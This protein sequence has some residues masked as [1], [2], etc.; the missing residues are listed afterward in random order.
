MPSSAVSPYLQAID[1][2]NAKI[3][4]ERNQ[5]KTEVIYYISDVDNTPSDW[6]ISEVRALAAV[7]TA[8]HV[9]ITLRIVVGPRRY[10]A[11]Q[12]LAKV[13]VFRAMHERVQRCQDP[14]TEFATFQ[15]W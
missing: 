5:Q 2:A 9:N 13:D 7:D 3:G 1:A 10:I 12:P 14:Q 8:V 6:K 4:A 15:P 11:D